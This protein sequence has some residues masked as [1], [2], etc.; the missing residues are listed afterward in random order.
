MKE[1]FTLLIGWSGGLSLGAVFSALDHKDNK[2]VKIWGTY[3][4]LFLMFSV[5]ILLIH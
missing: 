4:L 3:V 1:L 5:I 2:H